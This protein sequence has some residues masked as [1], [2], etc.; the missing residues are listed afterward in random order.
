VYA[1]S[2][3]IGSV[4]LESSS[5]AHLAKATACATVRLQDRVWEEFFESIISDVRI[6]SE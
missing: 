6:M 1:S 2:A 3:P 5:T 4:F